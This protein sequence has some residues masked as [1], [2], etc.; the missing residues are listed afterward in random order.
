MSGWGRRALRKWYEKRNIARE[1]R[2][3]RMQDAKERDEVGVK[4]EMKER[5][6]RGMRCV[7]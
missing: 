6:W 2:R 7:E 3:A 5:E 4:K 1:R